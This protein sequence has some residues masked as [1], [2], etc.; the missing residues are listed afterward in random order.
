MVI[1]KENIKSLEKYLSPVKNQKLRKSEEME[2][3]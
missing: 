2:K 1:K 3:I